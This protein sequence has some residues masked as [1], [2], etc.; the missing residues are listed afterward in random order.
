MAR[1]SFDR[2][3]F[4]AVF[5]DQKGM[6][7]DK[8][9]GPIPDWNAAW[10]N[11]H[12]AVPNAPTTTLEFCNAVKELNIGTQDRLCHLLASSITRAERSSMTEIDSDWLG[13]PAPKTTM[14]GFFSSATH[15]GN[16]FLLDVD[17]IPDAIHIHVQRARGPRSCVPGHLHSFVVDLEAPTLIVQQISVRPT[18]RKQGLC[19]LFMKR[20]KSV[21]ET[22][23]FN[24]LVQALLSDE[25]IRILKRLGFHSLNPPCEERGGDFGLRVGASNPFPL[26]WNLHQV[27]V[28]VPSPSDGCSLPNFDR[29]DAKKLFAEPFFAKDSSHRIS[30]Y[31][32]SDISKVRSIPRV[33]L[34]D[35][36]NLDK[37]AGVHADL[38]LSSS[39]SA[40]Y[41]L[42]NS[43]QDSKYACSMRYR[44][45]GVIMLLK[46]KESDERADAGESSGAHQN[47]NSPFDGVCL[48]E[49]AHLNPRK[50][51]MCTEEE[52]ASL[53]RD[54]AT[55]AEGFEETLLNLLRS[56]TILSNFSTTTTKIKYSEVDG[57]GRLI[58]ELGDDTHETKVFVD[59]TEKKAHGYTRREISC[60]TLAD[61]MMN[62]MTG[63]MLAYLAG[64][65]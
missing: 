39:A 22:L 64:L 60:D 30:K 44:I 20:L 7:P 16:A 61:N 43:V 14:K 26:E 13:T 28:L 23:G 6:S 41:L 21:A 17:D 38:V 56:S 25:L 15:G 59:L 37:Y 49:A 65:K 53:E 63:Q 12:K 5:F 10:I 54:I 62:A 42:K 9:I 8:T 47:R 31:T 4:A 45:E 40:G 34:D 27:V 19:T 11:Q 36:D 18:F 52:E 48:D 50:R 46:T 58:Y 2:R 1:F 35:H 3:Y 51:K 55:I 57:D 24:L 33:H 32:L 29:G